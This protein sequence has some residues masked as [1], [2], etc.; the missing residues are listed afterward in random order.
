MASTWIVTRRTGTG[1][2]RYRVEWRTGG[3]ESRTRYGGSF[4][5]KADAVA[6]R[7]WISG[8]LANLRIP[9][10][11]VL[12]ESAATPTL[13]EA[14][15]RWQ[16]SR[17]D[18]RD[19]TTVQHRTALGR[20]LPVLGSRRVD[21]ITP[22]DVAALVAKLTGEGY[23]R[24]STRKSL[25][26]LAMVFDHEQISPNPARDRVQVRLPRQE[27]EE[28]EPP[29]AEHV[30]AAGWLL[31]PTYLV[32]MLTLEATG[33]RVGELEAARLGDLDERRRAW[34]VRA[35]VAQTRR[36][37]WVV[38]PDDLYAVIAGRLPAPEDRDPDGPRF[39]GVTSDRLRM[40]IGRA[41]RDAGVRRFG[42]HSLRHRYVSS[43]LA[44]TFEPSTAH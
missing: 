37:R 33:C 11:S 23:A 29:D 6:R 28:P 17:V 18:V 4:K 2:N 32:A 44:G 3:R 31:T 22:A 43:R 27:P 9:N 13:A 1:R 26:A 12:A 39:P 38:L 25:T 30:E 7:N 15:R 5:R 35:A 42:P 14:A 19:S 16:T 21:A 20:V 8:E 36:A 40:A 10:F 41:C 24:E 34:L